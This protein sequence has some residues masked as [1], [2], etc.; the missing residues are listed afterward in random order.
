MHFR[1]GK[2][3]KRQHHAAERSAQ[4]QQPIGAKQRVRPEKQPEQKAKKQQAKRGLEEVK[5]QRS[6][7]HTYLSVRRLSIRSINAFSSSSGIPSSSTK[8]DTTLTNEL[9]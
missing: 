6:H 2:F 5:Q 4:Q 8:A 3:P 7:H 1:H 9:S